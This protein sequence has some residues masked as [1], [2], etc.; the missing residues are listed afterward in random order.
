MLD[1]ILN[2]FRR[3]SLV[4]AAFNAFKKSVYKKAASLQKD[5][6]IKESYI[7][8]RKNSDKAEAYLI[9]IYENN[10]RT[11]TDLNESI[12]L[13]LLPKDCEEELRNNNVCRLIM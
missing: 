7:E 6:E 8:L 12:D 3:L 2:I 13:E 11:L 10:R 9:K 5:D 1:F 4:D